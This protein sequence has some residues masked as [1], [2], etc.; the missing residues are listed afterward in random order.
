MKNLNEMIDNYIHG[1]RTIV[2]GLA[3]KV[4]LNI[5]QL[6]ISDDPGSE[7]AAIEI[8]AAITRE[9]EPIHAY[10][11]NN[12]NYDEPALAKMLGAAFEKIERVMTKHNKYGSTDSEPRYVVQQTMIDQVK[13]HYGIEG[14][15]EL[16]NWM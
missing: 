2:E 13:D 1:T 6:Q 14:W 11:K 4:S 3:P 9:M 5:D 15:T 12:D 10:M 16:A 7:Q 8:S